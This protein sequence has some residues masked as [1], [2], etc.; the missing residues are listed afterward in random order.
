MADIF[1]SYARDDRSK[2]QLLAE[3]FKRRNWS[4]WWDTRLQAGEVWDEVIER[5]L[6]AAHCLVVLWSKTSIA[7]HWVRA[8]ANEG[9]Q[10]GI[11][12]PVLI[13]HVRPPL[14]FRLVQAE[15]LL[16]WSGEPS[17]AGLDRLLAAIE[18]FLGQQEQRRVATEQKDEQ[19][20]W[21]P[22]LPPRQVGH[23]K[24]WMIALLGA[25][26]L[27]AATGVAVYERGEESPPMPPS[28]STTQGTS[29]TSTTPP[30]KPAVEPDQPEAKTIAQEID[31]SYHVTG[32]NPDGTSYYGEANIK[33]KGGH[34]EVMWRIGNN[35]VF[36]GA[37]SFSGN[38][39]TIN[40]DGGIV[41]YVIQQD[42][43]L[44]GRW[45][46]GKATETLVPK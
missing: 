23:R 3:A 25:V 14:A 38:T 8:E 1:I 33:H 30:T 21:L 2:A 26:V 41:T 44:E 12:V 46:D 43:K 27:A 9:L 11:L 18:H 45:A 4:V 35:Q 40:W 31:G 28:P 10:R 13:E 22:R 42:G 17:H 39:L 24:R 6:N 36:Y 32:R 34:Y 19:S 20:N 7:R 37:G 16:G 5:E 15:S 29:G